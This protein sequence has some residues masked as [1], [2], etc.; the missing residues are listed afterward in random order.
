MAHFFVNVT[1][2]ANDLDRATVGLVLAK[3]AL[4]EGHQVTLFLSLDGIHLARADNYI[5]GLHEPTFPS[6]R[7]LFDAL[8]NSQQ[9]RIWV[10]AGCYKKRGLEETNFIQQAEIVGA[11]AAIKAMAEPGIVPVYY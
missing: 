2:A 11:G 9:A 1:H 6:I 4:A 5:D 3:N 10:C 7:E 8:V